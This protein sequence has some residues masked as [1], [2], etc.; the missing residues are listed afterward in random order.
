VMALE[1]LKQ[2]GQWQAYWLIQAKIP[3]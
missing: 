2:S 1:A 3:A